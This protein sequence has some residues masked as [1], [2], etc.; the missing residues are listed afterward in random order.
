MLHAGHPQDGD[1]DVAKVTTFYETISGKI[2]WSTL[3][4]RPRLVIKERVGGGLQFTV[5]EVERKNDKPTQVTFV[6]SI[7]FD[8]FPF[9]PCAVSNVMES[10]LRY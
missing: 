10:P 3:L 4:R 5:H 7:F 9:S 8:A 6:S 2:L 1:G